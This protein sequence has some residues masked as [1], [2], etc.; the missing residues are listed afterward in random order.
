MAS[1]IPG[2]LL[3]LLQSM[4][5]NVKVRGEYRSVLLQVISIV[6][7]LSGSELWPNQG[8]FLKVS[9]S[10]HST[11]V[12]LSKQDNELILNN[13]LQLGQFFYVDK[14]E[15][16]T[17]VPV[18]VG[19]RPVPG[20][21]PFVGTPKDLMQMLEPSKSPMQA[22]Q[23]AKSGAKSKS[24]SET[25]NDG[26]RHKIVIKEEKAN[27]SSRY[28]QGVLS[29]NTRSGR[30]DSNGGG[31]RHE[32]EDGEAGK[33]CS[34]TEA[35]QFSV[36]EASAKSKSIPAKGTSNKQENMNVNCLPK[37]KDQVHSSETVSW[38]SLPTSLLKTGKGMLRR[39]NI[40]S[41]VAIEAQKEATAA[42][43]MVKCLSVFADLCSSASPEN[44]Q[45]PL[46]KFF[47]LQ[48]LISQTNS[49]DSAKDKSLHLTANSSLPEADK[50]TKITSLFQSKSASSKPAK[51]A[52]ELKESEKQ[53][54]AKGDGAKEIKLLREVLIKESTSWFLN[55]L[56]EALKVGFHIQNQDSK[57]WNNARRQ[58][59]ADNHIAVALSQLKQVNEWLEKL[60][61]NLSSTD[62]GLRETIEKL[63]QD[64]YCC[65]LVHAKS[66]ASAL[67]S[68]PDHR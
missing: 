20:R 62:S 6:P 43:S 51:A 23:K 58:T 25:K 38:A 57:G 31:R 65:L 13:N 4:N 18:L 66:A 64:V 63:K 67:E 35:L 8:F 53:E 47:T 48:E 7:A 34:K 40:A 26:M 29:L 3:K 50:S 11:Y 55:F 56:E 27:V 68:R 24:I 61:G 32:N 37:R 42:A 17:P 39:K 49:K 59:V 22:N 41:M 10:S 15:A 60:K 21:Q 36:K 1:L 14:M 12:S 19:I 28:M 30:F 5:S 46:A 54:W 9:D 16:G 52:I 2:V 45:L 44:P 33:D